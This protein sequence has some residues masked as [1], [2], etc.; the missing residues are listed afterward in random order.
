LRTGRLPIQQS[1]AA[2]PGHVTK[3][4]HSILQLLNGLFVIAEYVEDGSMLDEDCL[5]GRIM[6]RYLV[7]QHLEMPLA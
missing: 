6:A 7:V 3:V 1:V 2:N 5:E 4:L